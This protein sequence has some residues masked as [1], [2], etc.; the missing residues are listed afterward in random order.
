MVGIENDETAKGIIPRAFKHIFTEMN[1]TKNEEN[2]NFLVRCSF[3]EIYNDSIKDLLNQSN[4]TDDIEHKSL[5]LR[6]HPEK[7]VYVKDLKYMEVQTEEALQACF[8]IGNNYRHTAET[9]MN[10]DSSRS[11]S[12]FTIII[13]SV[14][15]DVVDAS[16]ENIR[17]GK[18]HLVDL[19]GSERQKKTEAKGLR[20]T[21]AIN[22]NLSLS[23]LGN[24]INALTSNKKLKHI[25]YR[26]SKLTRILQDSLGGNSKTV[27]IANICSADYNYEE[28]MSTLRFAN[29]AKSIKNKP[30]INQDPK[31]KLLEEYKLQIEELKQRLA[32]KQKNGDDV[33]DDEME[34]QVIP[35]IIVQKVHKIG[36]SKERV[37]RMHD[38]QQREEEK[39]RIKHEREKK[40]W[41]KETKNY[42]SKKIKT[43]KKLKYIEEEVLLKKQIKKENIRK[44]LLDIEQK[45]VDGEKMIHSAKKQEQQL[46]SKRQMLAEIKAKEE[47]LRR[48]YQKKHQKHLKLKEKYDSQGQELKDK[49]NKLLKLYEKYKSLSHNIESLQSSFQSK[50]EEYL[51]IIRIL[52]KKIQLKNTIIEYFVDANQLQKLYQSDRIVIEENEDVADGD[53]DEEIEKLYKI[54]KIDLQ[55]I[56]NTIQRPISCKQQRSNNSSNGMNKM[57]RIKPV[58]EW[59]RIQCVL[60]QSDNP[61]YR[62]ENIIQLQMDMPQ[63]TTQDYYH[64]YEE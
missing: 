13:E 14:I 51:N 53:Q 56:K 24:V 47:K 1:K 20:F 55:N 16:K 26:D 45:L 52:K 21:E 15:K 49:K 25:P 38:M 54:K 30:H 18:L 32:N 8:K 42:L 60:L 40:V 61:R 28:T 2:N 57:K 9:A 10:R 43:E 41:Q 36:I 59:N 31:D 62:Y 50:R 7:G 4:Q 22:I 63:R 64:M 48:D 27:M 37:R 35:K 33:I 3:I 44:K 17:V 34:E 39:L 29:R 46:L 23:A 58:T 11:H 6:E 19:A 5:E 12:V